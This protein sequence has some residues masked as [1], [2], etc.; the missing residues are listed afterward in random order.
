M[1]DCKLVR[2]YVLAF[3]LEVAI[4]QICPLCD[5]KSTT[6]FENSQ[7][8][9]KK[10]VDCCFDVVKKWVASYQFLANSLLIPY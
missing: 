7:K 8:K 4:N 1:G 10:I 2:V 3:F 9:E 5:C 6:F